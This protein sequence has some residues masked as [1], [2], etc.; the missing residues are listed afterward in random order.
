LR[1]PSGHHGMANASPV[2]VM[3][4]TLFA[5]DPDVRPKRVDA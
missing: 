4:V 1:L 3:V 5:A 2:S